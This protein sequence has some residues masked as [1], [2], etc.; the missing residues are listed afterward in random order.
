MAL[1]NDSLWYPRPC[2]RGSRADT[3]S[4]A[5]ST[6]DVAQVVEVAAKLQRLNPSGAVSR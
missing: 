2:A 6:C 5:L 1:N 3:A 4:A